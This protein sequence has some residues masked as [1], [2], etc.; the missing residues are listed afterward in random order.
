M[1]AVVP[2]PMVRLAGVGR[3]FGDTVACEGVSF[4]LAAGQFL[5]ILGPSGS[6]KTT[7]LRMIAGFL[8][9]S[10]GEIGSTA[11][12]W[13]RCRPTGARSAWCSSAWPCSRT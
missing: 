13:P 10:E 12:R 1:A 4:A 3:R 5:T 7:V 2:E 9:P 6:G 11:G 8:A